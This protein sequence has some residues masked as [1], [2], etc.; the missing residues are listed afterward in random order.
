MPDNLPFADTV[1]AALW[2]RWCQRLD[3]IISVPIETT[4]QALARVLVNQH[5]PTCWTT[6]DGC[7]PCDVSWRPNGTTDWRL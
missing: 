7:D 5:L 3:V 1:A 6:W 2:R 4:M